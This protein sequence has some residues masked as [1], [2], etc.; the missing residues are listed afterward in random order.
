MQQAPPLTFNSAVSWRLPLGSS[1]RRLDLHANFNWVETQQYTAY[2]DPSIEQPS[3]LYGF[4]SLTYRPRKHHWQ[5]SV[6]VKNLFDEEYRRG[7]DDLSLFGLSTGPFN[8]PRQFG[9][10]FRI[11]SGL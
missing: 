3:Y 2:N 8:P 11:H 9:L 7:G 10:T 5:A 6:W 1:G 4:A